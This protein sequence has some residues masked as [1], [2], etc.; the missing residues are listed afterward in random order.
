M[1]DPTFNPEDMGE[2]AENS[3]SSTGE[4]ATLQKK[5]PF[6]SVLLEY[7]EILVLSVCVVLLI[8]TFG[9]RLCRVNGNSMNKTLLHGEM[10]ITSS[11]SEPEAGDIIVFHMTSDTYAFINEPLVKRVIAKEGQTVKIDYAKGEVFVDGVLLDEPY[12]ALLDETN[13]VDIGYW[14]Q[15]PSHSFEPKTLTFEATVPEGCLFVMGD[16][17]NNS[18]DS[19]MVE[20]GLVDE[21]RVLGKVVC[22]LNPY[23]KFD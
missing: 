20:V 8:F 14:T 16:N 23:T 17:R 22:R 3:P 19:R 13:T 1:S 18:A 7:V 21:R 5:E 9:I 2:I 11:L 10:L 6:V 15:Y 4:T 12:V